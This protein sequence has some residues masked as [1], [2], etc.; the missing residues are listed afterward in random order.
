VFLTL[1]GF[2]QWGWHAN[3]LSLLPT[4]YDERT[5]DNQMIQVHL[6]LHLRAT[7]LP[8]TATV[9][10]ELPAWLVFLELQF[11]RHTY[12]RFHENPFSGCLV[13]RGLTDGQMR[14]S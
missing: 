2:D 11:S 7:S 1:F 3:L 10:T 14:R 8:A 13:A 4:E 6:Q 5:N 9:F 12:F